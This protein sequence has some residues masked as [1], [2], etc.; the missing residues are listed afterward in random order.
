[1]LATANLN[2]QGAQISVTRV[3]AI[4]VRHIPALKTSSLI[5]ELM[6]RAIAATEKVVME[7]AS[8]LFSSNSFVRLKWMCRDASPYND[9]AFSNSI[10]ILLNLLTFC[11]YGA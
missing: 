1:M 7:R 2:T 8:I 11:F 5:L 4:E 10:D 3:N 9:T 6:Y